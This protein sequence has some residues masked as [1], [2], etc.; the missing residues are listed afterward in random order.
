M[1]STLAN[2]FVTALSR[3]SDVPS[4][5][6]HRMTALHPDPTDDQ[7]S[8]RRA[9]RVHPAALV[10]LFAWA[11]LLLLWLLF[12]GTVGPVEVAAG[13]AVGLI[14][15]AYGMR[16][17]SHLTDAAPRPEWVITIVRALGV[18][19]PRDV[20]RVLTHFG[21]G[22]I[23]RIPFELIGTGRAARA[24]V[25]AAA[26]AASTPPNS[27]VVEV[28]HSALVVHQFAPAPTP[29]DSKWPI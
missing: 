24:H 27:I 13:A 4:V 20:F 16:V 7:K 19:I 15:A 28:E 29:S 11:V 6:P 12:F 2:W 26:T 10:R 17:V 8:G 9:Q 22:K 21:N 23:D 3:A 14:A 25:T 18:G 1:N 5:A